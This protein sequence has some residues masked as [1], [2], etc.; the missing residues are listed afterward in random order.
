MSTAQN[1]WVRGAGAFPA[2]SRTAPC[3]HGEKGWITMWTIIAALIV[4]CIIG[5][6][7]RLVLPG[8][9]NISLPITVVLGALGSL[10]GSALYTFLLDRDSTSAFH[11]IGFLLGIG[12]AVVLV[13]VYGAVTGKDNTHKRIRS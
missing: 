8:K 12:V 6:L 10:G 5:P 2:V 7:A 1:V 13:L 11:P 4:G 3:P 9:Q